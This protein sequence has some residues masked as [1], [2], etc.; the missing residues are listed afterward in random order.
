MVRDPGWSRWAAGDD[1]PADLGSTGGQRVT[2]TSAL[3]QLAV[4]GSAGLIADMIAT[5]PVEVQ[6]PVDG[7][8]VAAPASAVPRW[9]EQP[10]PDLDRVA[11]VT[12]LTLS[13]LLDGNAFVVPLLDNRGTVA[14]VHALDPKRVSIDKSPSGD[15]VYLVDGARVQTPILH[16]P[17]LVL[18][19][20]VRGVSPVEMARQ[21]IG[22]GLGVNDQAARFFSQGTI[23]PGVIETQADLS[24]EQMRE[25]RDQWISSHGGS[26]R[27]HL[28]VVLGAAKFSPIAMTAEQAQFLESRKFT[29]AQIA[30]QLFRLDPSFLG[31]PVEGQGLLYQNLEARASHLVRVTLMPWLVRLERLMTRLLPATQR[32]RF[33]VDGLLRADLTTRYSAYAT[34]ASI[35]LLTIDE[36]RQLEDR[37]P[38]E[39]QSEELADAR[40]IAELI[41]KIYLGVDKVITADEAREI[42]NRAGAGLT[43]P[44][45][46]AAA[47]RAD[48]TAA[49]ELRAALSALQSERT[50]G[51]VPDMHLHLP[52]SIIGQVELRQEQ[53]V[54]PAPIVN[55][56]APIVNVTV[57]P[58]PVTV[59]VEAPVVTVEAPVVNV[60]QV[61]VTVDVELHQPQGRKSVE[62]VRDRQGRIAGAELLEEES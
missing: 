6:S 46:F 57:E 39:S 52:E 44:G 22:I 26:R 56:P 38:L 21:I 42:A 40:G 2:A 34:A 10:N 15:A 5:L 33:N 47:A 55:V 23:T 8:Y 29:D 37:P 62:F 60:P 9:V 14:E 61:P 16:S 19:G 20:S 35:G 25:I 13:L 17:A 49:A 1:L 11:L 59:D 36:M 41:Q 31:I 48:E 58:T 45:P 32:W 50:R 12:Q 27:A 53:V 3:G 54:I 24:V 30:G 51:A 4:Y 18:A 7:R 28:P 43:M